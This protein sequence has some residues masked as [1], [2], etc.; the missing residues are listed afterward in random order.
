MLQGLKVVG[1]DRA[2]AAPLC[3]RILADWGADVIK[4][5]QPG[6]GDFSRGWD[7]FVEGQSSYFVLLNRGKRSLALDLKREEGR[8]A[9]HAVLAGSDVFT[10]ARHLP[11]QAS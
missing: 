5:E 9:L 3:T 11:P 2:V 7:T 6:G 8:A 4:I 10:R 1:L